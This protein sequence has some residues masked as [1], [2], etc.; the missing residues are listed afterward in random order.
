MTK[1]HDGLPVKGY[2]P[3]DQERIDLAD[4]CKEQ[5]ELS[6]R[7]IEALEGR[8]DCDHRHLAI[9]KTNLQQGWMWAVRAIF[10]PGRIK[11][12]GDDKPGWVE[13]PEQ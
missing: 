4:L 9:A 13:P 3:Q 6:M 1:V 7:L 8:L 10:Q 5:E 11:L 12:P 2:R